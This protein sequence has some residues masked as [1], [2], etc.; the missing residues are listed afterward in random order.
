[1]SLSGW[2]TSI[3]RMAPLASRHLSSSSQPSVNILSGIP[4][5]HAAR[6]V[7]IYKPTKYVN[8]PSPV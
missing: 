3:R 6:R 1:M 7:C 4:D 2:G 5:K 8:A